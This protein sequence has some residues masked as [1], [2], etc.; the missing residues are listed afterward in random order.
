M[1]ARELRAG[2]GL[3]IRRCL[4]A[5]V[6]LLAVFATAQQLRFHAVPPAV[7]RGIQ[8]AAIVGMLVT[9]GFMARR[10]FRGRRRE[11]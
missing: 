2:D 10:R 4:A 1:R 7:V 6:C 8:G 3:V 5:Q 11:R 9:L